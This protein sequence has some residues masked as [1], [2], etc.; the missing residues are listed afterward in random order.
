MNLEETKKLF[1]SLIG[2]KIALKIKGENK[3]RHGILE[4]IDT[5]IF[6]G[7]DCGEYEALYLRQPSRILAIRLKEIEKIEGQGKVS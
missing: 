2:V 4:K 5:Q 7:L 6:G 1:Q 3:V